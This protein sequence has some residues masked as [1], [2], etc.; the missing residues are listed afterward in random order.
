MHEDLQSL[1]P[2]IEFTRREFAVT[3]LVAGFALAAPP[4]VQPVSARTLTTEESPIWTTDL[5]QNEDGQR[6]AV[7]NDTFEWWYFDTIMDDGSTCVVTFLNKPPFNSGPLVPIL[8]F[9]ISPPAGGYFQEV[10]PFSADQYSASSDRCDVTMGPNRVVGDLQTYELHV[11]GHRLRADLVLQD[12]VP[13]FRTGPYLP[14]PQAA[15]RFL[16]E[17]IVIPSGTVQGFLTYDGVLHEVSGT[18]YHDHQ[19]GGS[20]KTVGTVRVTSWFWGGSASATIPSCSP[21]YSVPT[22]AV[23]LC[24]SGP[25]S[26]LR[27]AHA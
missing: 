20:Q 5:A 13:G 14:P 7:T 23:P 15:E 18:C 25:C 26:C 21:R 6:V 10:I 11:E 4:A 22:E 16:G 3:A 24:R 8:L 9:N 19:W 2:K 27:V 17:Q 12:V 1:K